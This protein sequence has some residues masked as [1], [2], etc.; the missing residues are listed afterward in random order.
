[1]T[2]IAGLFLYFPQDKTEYFPAA[3]SFLVFFIMAVF[4][5]RLIIKVSRKELQKQKDAEDRMKKWKEDH[6]S[7]T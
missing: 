5:M 3:I 1:V 4:V 6:P 7:D 2:F